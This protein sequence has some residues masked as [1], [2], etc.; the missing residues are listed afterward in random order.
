[1]KG[2]DRLSYGVIGAALEVHRVLGPD[3]LEATYRKC[4]VHEL[5]CRRL[6]C[7]EEL[8]LPVRYKGLSLP[9]DYYRLDIVVQNRLI[10]ELKSVDKLLPVH[11]A[12]ILTY[13]R[14]SKIPLGLLI[15]FNAPALKQGIHRYVL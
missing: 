12:Q 15:N 11:R 3:L 9:D 10:L 13:L 6:D 1:M 2:F 8:K 7:K 14:L 5:R 4:L